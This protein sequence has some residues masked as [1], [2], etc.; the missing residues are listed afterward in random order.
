MAAPVIN[1]VRVVYPQGRSHK[2]PGE[3]AEVFVD[4]VDADAH[5][6]EVTVVVRDTAGNEATRAA[7]VVQGDPLTYSASTAAAGH[8]VTQDPATPT[9]FVVV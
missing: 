1:D 4:A 8:T 6:V 7:L 3:A 9:R 5:S 2:Y